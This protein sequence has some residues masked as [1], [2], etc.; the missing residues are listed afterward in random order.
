MDVS[1]PQGAA[2]QIAKLVEHEERVIAGAP[3]MAVVGATLLFAVSR[4]FARIHV[5]HDN[6]RLAP[7]V[8]RVD[9]LARQVGEGSEVLRPHQPLGLE[10]AHLAGGGSRPFDRPI[11][12]HPAYC[13]V[14]AQPVGVVHVLV[15]G[16][17]SED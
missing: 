11:A 16:K 15:A 14:A 5:Q 7:L 12:D 4:A 2:L 13:R 10:A 1:G 8:H 9:P 17:P 3:E 6:L